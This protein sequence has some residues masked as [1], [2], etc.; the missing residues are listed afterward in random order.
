MAF[1]TKEQE[2]TLLNVNYAAQTPHTAHIPS[3]PSISF[4]I[5]LAILY[6]YSNI[7]SHTSVM[8]LSTVKSYFTPALFGNS[9]DKENKDKFSQHYFFLVCTLYT[10]IRG[11][12]T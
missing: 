6:Y 4:Y 10:K 3:H 2:A 12:H 11:Y 7:V 8:M 5:T 1:Q 9:K